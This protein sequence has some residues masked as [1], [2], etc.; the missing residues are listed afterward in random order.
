M[1]TSPSPREPS[2]LDD[3]KSR[4][5][6]LGTSPTQ[7]RAPVQGHSALQNKED[8]GPKRP[9]LR[10]AAPTVHDMVVAALRV[11]AMRHE[12][13]TTLGSAEIAKSV[14]SS[15]RTV[16][17]AVEKLVGDG[18]VVRVARR[19]NDIGQFTRRALVFP[20]MATETTRM[21]TRREA[22]AAPTDGALRSQVP[23]SMRVS[24]SSAPRPAVQNIDLISDPRSPTRT[25]R[26][27]D[28]GGGDRRIAEGL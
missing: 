13:R 4:A 14:G 15:P 21:W 26:S 20:D 28:L 16:R 11:D 8:C 10:P 22:L 25:D 7:P 18:L 2:W 12:G 19:R 9:K 6:S 23:R 5:A 27:T 24:P 17:R 3:L 1:S